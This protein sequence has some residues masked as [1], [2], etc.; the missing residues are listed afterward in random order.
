MR[1]NSLFWIFLFSFF[2]GDNFSIQEV[3]Y[4]NKESLEISFSQ[5]VLLFVCGVVSICFFFVC[6]L[7]RRKKKNKF[8]V[9][10]DPPPDTR[11]C[12]RAMGDGA[13]DRILGRVHYIL[14]V[15]DL[16]NEIKKKH[17]I[18]KEKLYIK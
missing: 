17:L 6:F 13:G 15:Q 7:F 11:K 8:K 14:T 12:C 1:E 4:R 18:F 16:L 10:K 5:E 9:S 2:G 3:E